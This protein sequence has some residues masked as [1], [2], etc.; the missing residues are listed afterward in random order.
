[1][2]DRFWRTIEEPGTRIKEIFENSFLTT[3]DN[4]LIYPQPLEHQHADQHH[5]S[6]CQTQRN[7]QKESITAVLKLFP[8]T[9]QDIFR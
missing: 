1:M 9:G 5:I 7:L 3:R 8:S 2:I 4:T 6:Q